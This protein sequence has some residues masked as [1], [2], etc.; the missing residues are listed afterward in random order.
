M[1]CH[2]SCALALYLLIVCY[3]ANAAPLMLNGRAIQNTFVLT[4]PSPQGCIEGQIQALNVAIQDA[5]T[6]A[7]VAI[8][9]LAQPGIREKQEYIDLLGSM[10]NTFIHLQSKLNVYTMQPWLF[11]RPSLETITCQLSNGCPPLFQLV[12]LLNRGDLKSCSAVPP[13]I[14]V[15]IGLPCAWT[16][17][18]HQTNT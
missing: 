14:F 3:L 18:S 11:Q 5:K 17:T 12:R 6:L 10:S 16:H 7:N 15:R 8:E 4:E 9:A 13:P 2:T 1:L